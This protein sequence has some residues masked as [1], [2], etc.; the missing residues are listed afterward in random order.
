M[1]SDTK[2]DVII[3]GGGPAGGLLGYYLACRNL[4]ILII[5]K[6]HLP[7]YKACGGGLT[8]RA[9]KAI[10]FDISDVVEDYTYTA[11]MLLM[12][13][14]LFSKTLDRP[15][16]A[17]VM[18][19]RFDQFLIEKAVSM[20]AVFQENTSFRTISGK[21]G[22][23]TVTTSKGKFKTQIIA[24]A[25]GVNSR[26]SKILGLRVKCNF[27]TAIEGEVYPENPADIERFKGSVHY[28]FGVIPKGYG[29]VF[30]KTTHLSIGVGTFS[31]K[32]KNWKQSLNSYLAL[33]NL[34]SYKKLKPLKGHLI[35]FRPKRNNIV[36]CSKGLLVGDASG[37]ADPLTGEGL[38]YA[39]Q[40]A[41]IASEAIIKGFE[42]EFE[43]I[44]R[45]TKSIKKQFQKDLICAGRMAH[46]IY[47]FPNLG[48]RILN[49]HAD[50][51]ALKQLA[52]ICGELTYSKLF[53]ELLL[54]MMSP[55]KIIPVI[56]KSL[57]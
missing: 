29:W 12:D 56:F 22:D 47:T 8:R 54:Q 32:L 33:K 6:K 7:R 10:P 43:H 21:T 18:R 44:N 4:K 27:M 5:E 15:I 39:I 19:D 37:F 9:F 49:V 25:D 20:G 23:L 2:Y 16:I 1:Q 24:G 36:S 50:D 55:S 57:S 52:V 38:Y 51:L 53:R 30:P 41:K 14:P 42:S 48:R 28:D 46:M 13:R 35:P 40:G 45:Y 34:S 11:K 3:V 17:M 31:P 26:V